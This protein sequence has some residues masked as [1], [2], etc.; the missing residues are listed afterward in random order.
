LERRNIQGTYYNYTP[1]ALMRECV[2]PLHNP[3]DLIKE[4]LDILSIRL[5]NALSSFEIGLISEAISEMLAGTH[6]YT[7]FVMGRMDFGEMAS[8]DVPEV[9][10][11]RDNA[12]NLLKQMLEHPSPEVKLAG[13]QIAEDIGRRWG[14]KNPEKKLPLAHRIAKD[15]E[16]IVEVI[17][18]LISAE[19]DFKILNGIETLFLS[20]GR[21][22]SLAQ[23]E[24]RIT[25]EIFHV[26]L[27]I[28]LV[29]FLFLLI[30]L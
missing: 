21:K 11:L 5:E 27:N 26:R 1:K 8:L 18:N 16:E 3:R 29:A 6:E 7:R 28:S 13:I 15:R 23:I 19:G 2:S 22:R 4:T 25:Y 17:G 20:G 14:G 12:L 9:R 24:Q 10:K 30:L